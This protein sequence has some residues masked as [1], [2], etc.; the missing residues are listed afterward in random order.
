MYWIPG[1]ATAGSPTISALTLKVTKMKVPAKELIPRVPQLGR[2][3][4]ERMAFAHIVRIR[5]MLFTPK[6]WQNSML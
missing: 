6:C 5:F 1:N 2:P 4:L 3:M